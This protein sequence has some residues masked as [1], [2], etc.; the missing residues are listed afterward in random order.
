MRPTLKSMG[1]DVL[2]LLRFKAPSPAI[3]QYW[4]HYL[5]FALACTW[6]AGIGRYWDHPNAKLWQYL[7]LGSV[8]YV[9]CLALIV[10]LLLLPL[11]PKRWS[12][13]NVL[14]FIALTSPPALLYAI[15]VERFMT[16]DAA[17]AVNVWFL[18]VV[19]SWRVAL[20][21][22]FLRKIAG[23][24]GIA[25]LIGSML[26]LVMILVALTMLNLEH[27]AF[28]LMSGISPEN[29]TPND[30]AYGIVVS[31]SVLSILAAP[32]LLAGYFVLVYLAWA[33]KMD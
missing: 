28:E 3:S 30:T 6:L 5:I 7:G 31:L 10:W 33:K 26:P 20:L 25:I 27:A 32:F 19:A 13:R 1:Y 29:R 2:N 9:F 12:Y 11:K 15:P 24:T 21:I 18:A 16:I 4:Q 22:W 23:L 17:Q 8:I 14:I